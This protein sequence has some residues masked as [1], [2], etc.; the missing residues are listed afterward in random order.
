MS[1]NAT[2]RPTMRDI[3]DQP[4][5]RDLYRIIATLGQQLDNFAGELQ[6]LRV[7]LTRINTRQNDDI[8]ANRDHLLRLDEELGRVKV[9]LEAIKAW[10]IAHQFT[11]PFVG[12]SSQAA[13]RQQLLQLLVRHFN[14]DELDNLLFEMGEQPDMLPSGN[15]TSRAQA[16]VQHMERRGRIDDLIEACRR[17][18]PHVAWP[19][20]YT[21]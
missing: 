13:A 2:P 1:S 16:I 6:G 20:A 3:P 15:L 10:Q 8:Q 18:R 4:T 17:H 11:C 21:S 7:D 14:Q 12:V 9:E 19:L 5:L